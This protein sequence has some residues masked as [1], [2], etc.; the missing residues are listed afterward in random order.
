MPTTFNS[1]QGCVTLAVRNF[2][3]GNYFFADSTNSVHH[4]VRDC[5]NSSSEYRHHYFEHRIADLILSRGHIAGCHDLYWRHH[6]ALLLDRWCV[7]VTR[8]GQ[9]VYSLHNQSAAA[10]SAGPFDCYKRNA[11]T[12]VLRLPRDLFTKS[13]TCFQTPEEIH[14]DQ[15]FATLL[16][17]F[18]FALADA[19]ASPREFAADGLAATARAV[20]QACVNDRSLTRYEPPS[21]LD[22]AWLNKT[23]SIV[24]LNMSCADFGPA[25]LAVLLGM[26]RSKL[27][28]IFANFGGVQRFITRERL[29]EARRRLEQHDAGS[30]KIVV[31]DV[32]FVDHS[33]FSRAFRR[34]FGYC[35]REIRE[36]MRSEIYV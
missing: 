25:E 18:V 7:I 21:V 4:K 29:L 2:L 12:I 3:P 5:V 16:A 13:A 22:G 1:L 27:Y 10:V 26:S 36:R 8:W 11:D 20:V 30:V 34:E 23:K 9:P 14:V 19:F 15:N 28:R 33:T 24:K 17:C 31:T 6:P 32:G 35:P